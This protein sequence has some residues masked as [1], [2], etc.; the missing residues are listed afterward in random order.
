MKSS[1]IDGF[2]VILTLIILVLF[3]IVGAYVGYTDMVKSKERRVICDKTCKPYVV[4]VCRDDLIVC[5]G[6]DGGTIIEK[7]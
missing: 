1:T 6:I 2:F 4:M 7:E 5:D 3:A